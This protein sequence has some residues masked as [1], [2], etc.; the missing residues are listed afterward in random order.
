MNYFILTEA[1]SDSP[2]TLIIEAK[3]NL[4]QMKDALATKSVVV[5]FIKI[6]NRRTGEGSNRVRYMYCTRSPT[7]IKSI[8]MGHKLP[9]PGSEGYK[10][11]KEVIPVFDLVKK[12]WRSFDV[13][14]VKRFQIRQMNMVDRILRKNRYDRDFQRSIFR[15]PLKNKFV[16]TKE[17]VD[18]YQAPVVLHALAIGPK[19]VS[20]AEFVG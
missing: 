9:G 5:K 7:I 3:M 14:T 11:P 2:M 19:S 20:F 8:G 18:E 10:G 6:G 12:A 1:D 13:R 17:S 16:V 15:D 4:Q